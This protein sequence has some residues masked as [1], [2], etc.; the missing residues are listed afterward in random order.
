MNKI[1]PVVKTLLAA[2]FFTM[3]V[4]GC[5]LL[6]A[7]YDQYAY[8]QT[9]SLKVDVLNLMDKAT[10]SYTDHSKDVE[11]VNTELMKNI[12]YEKHREKNQITIAMYNILWKLLNDSTTITVGPTKFKHGF[13]EEWKSRN[14]LQSHGKPDVA[15]IEEAKT[16]IGEGFDMIAE[17]ESRKIKPSDSNVQSFL[18]RNK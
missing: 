7:S 5:K 2:I 13:F 16:Q 6:I 17:L 9:T 12:E 10:E 14:A 1:K 4:H 8:T 18:S 11:D 3:I 15:F